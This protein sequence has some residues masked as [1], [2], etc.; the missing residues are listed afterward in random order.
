MWREICHVCVF[1]FF[2]NDTATTEIYTLSLHDALPI[3]CGRRS[4]YCLLFPRLAKL[5]SLPDSRIAG[6]TYL[7]NVNRDEFIVSTGHSHQVYRECFLVIEVNGACI[8]RCSDMY[9][10]A[11]DRSK[12]VGKIPSVIKPAKKCF[13]Y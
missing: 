7:A 1:F 8:V 11:V 9:M 6:T 5:G 12:A 4:I 2:F 3:W 10:F 13:A